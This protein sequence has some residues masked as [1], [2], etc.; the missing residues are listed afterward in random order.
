MANN[1]DDG[2]YWSE[3][4]GRLARKGLGGLV[5]VGSFV[6][7]SPH[8]G[9]EW[10]GENAG[11]FAGG[12]I[13]GEPQQPRLTNPTMDTRNNPRGMAAPVNGGYPLYPYR[14]ELRNP[15]SG[16]SDIAQYGP[17][18]IDQN[19]T[20][21]GPRRDNS[22]PVSVAPSSQ[23]TPSGYAPG[24]AAETIDMLISGKHPSQQPMQ[25]QQPPQGP[26]GS[27]Q[28]QQGGFRQIPSYMP[29]TNPNDPGAMSGPAIGPGGVLQSQPWERNY[30]AGGARMNPMAQSFN[31]P[32]PAKGWQPQNPMQQLAQM[33]QQGDLSIQQANAGRGLNPAVQKARL[34]AEGKELDRAER[35]REFDI[36]DKRTGQSLDL[37]KDSLTEASQ[38]AQAHQAIE[39]GKLD[40]MELNSKNQGRLI[41]YRIDQGIKDHKENSAFRDGIL[42]LRQQGRRDKIVNEL[43]NRDMLSIKEKAQ[44]LESIAK[45]GSSDEKEAATKELAIIE[46][47][48]QGYDAPESLDDLMSYES[49]MD[50]RDG[51]VPQGENQQPSVA[52]PVESSGLKRWKE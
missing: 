6:A 4:A 46:K 18:P 43:A 26:Q 2:S 3:E 9:G 28:P 5:D 34:G 50:S 17:G 39:Q 48:L 1:Y 16:V 15:I 30:L 23:A 52:A 45:N 42:K 35:A 13:Y 20:Q 19:M 21:L 33:N 37:R 25:P 51:T 49:P 44:M 10:L 7:N 38:I 27:P 24:S 41:G 47:Q 11:R 12:L 29:P 36:K 31:G 32:H 22:E 8:R 14:G 40:I